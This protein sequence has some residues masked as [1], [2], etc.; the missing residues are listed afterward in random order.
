MTDAGIVGPLTWAE[1]MRQHTIA[2]SPPYPGVLQRVG[3]S[4]AAVRTI[5]ERLNIVARNNPSITT[6]LEDG[7]FGPRTQASVIA[8][9]RLFGLSPDGIVGPLT[10]AELMRQSSIPGT[11]PPPPPSRRFTIVLDA[12]HGGSD[13]GAVHASRREKD[14]NLRLALAVQGLLQA[15]GQKV[16]MT[17]ST[18]VA[19]SLTQRSALSN[20]NNADLFVSIHRNS[21]TNTTANGVENFVF[22]T[23]NSTRALYAFNVLD[24]IVNAGVQNNR[25]VKRGNFAVLRNTNAPAMLLE[26]GFIS[27]TRDNQLFD[28]NFNAYAA[29]I[30]RGIMQSLNGPSTPPSSYFF[31]TVAAGDNLSSVA[32]RFGTTAAAITALNKLT[33]TT[34]VTGQILKIP[35]R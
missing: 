13:W 30:A 15:Q 35:S 17:R 34:I 18:D 11:S 10:W 3:S 32:A 28:Q 22:T 33:L 2:Q 5:Q 24:D 12:G 1:L 26:M 7:I 31:Y 16:I 9:Q 6:L 4:G 23:A 14:D 19:I 8:F 20:Q 25:G 29:A 21:S 27:N